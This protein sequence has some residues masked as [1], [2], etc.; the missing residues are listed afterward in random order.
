MDD[1]KNWPAKRID[2]LYHIASKELSES[3]FQNYEAIAL[4]Y[5]HVSPDDAKNQIWDSNA[6]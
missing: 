2:M 6:K 5:Y 3:N 4:K 1:I